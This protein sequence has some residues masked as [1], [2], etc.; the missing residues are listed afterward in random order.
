MLPSAR[1]ARMSTSPAQPLVEW[2]EALAPRTATASSSRHPQTGKS[3]HLTSC[4]ATPC[5]RMLPSARTARMS[6]SP[7][8]P[9]SSRAPRTRPPLPPSA[10]PWSTRCRPGQVPSIWPRCWPRAVLCAAPASPI[11]VSSRLRSR[12]SHWTRQMKCCP[13]AARIR[14]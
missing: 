3:P 4:C 2:R 8:Q 9:P 10:A 5:A 12:C 7:A 11:A 1:A 6:T 14:T 13:A